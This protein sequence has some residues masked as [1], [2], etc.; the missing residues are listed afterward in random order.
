MPP[1]VRFIHAV[2][3]AKKPVVAAVHGLVVGVGTTILLHCDLVYAATE[4]N[5]MMPFVNLGIVP[6]AASTVL[7]PLLIGRQ[8]ASE[9]FMLGAPLSAQ[10]AFEMGLVNAL[11]SRDQLL[12]TATTAAQALAAKPAAALRACKELMKRSLSSRGG[13]SPSRRSGSHLRTPG[14]ARNARSTQRV[15]GK[16]KAGLL[17][18][19]TSRPGARKTCRWTALRRLRFL[20][21]ANVLLA[22]PI[23]HTVRQFGVATSYLVNDQVLNSAVFE[24]LQQATASQP[25]VLAELCR[26]YVTEAR[27]TLTHLQEAIDQSDPV[28]LR[29]RAHYLKGS[30]MMLGAQDLSQAC[31][32]LERMGRDNEPGGSSI[33]PARTAA[34]L[35]EVEIE[36]A[37][38][39]GPAVLPAEGSAA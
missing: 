31:A 37:K 14:I 16:A 22:V 28:K 35:K 25:A 34:A 11:V 15:S 8:R 36:L 24:R 7:L 2:A 18:V 30:S 39:V 21:D 9:L 38:I 23:G 3:H 26:D 27:S 32:V 10:R 19:L 12:Q 29:E 1:A 13:S 6:E 17:Q 33:C 4:T 20:L 5:L